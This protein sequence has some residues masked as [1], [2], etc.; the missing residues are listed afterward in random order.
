MI[1]AEADG[2]RGW[3]GE[4]LQVA[5]AFAGVWVVLAAL[6]IGMYERLM[7]DRQAVAAAPL[8]CVMS[9]PLAE[10]VQAGRLD[11]PPSAPAAQEAPLGAGELAAALA[12]VRSRTGELAGGVREDDVFF[13]DV[14]SIADLVGADLRQASSGA[15]ARLISPFGIFEILPFSR[16]IRR[17]FEPTDLSH[18]TRVINASLHL[19]VRGLDSVLP[20]E[21]TWNEETRAWTLASDDR[22]MRIAVAEDLFEITIDRSDRT[23]TIHYAGQQ[24]VH[25]RCCTGEGNNSPV[26]RWRVQNKAVWPAWR[27]YEGEHIPGGS[28]RNPLGARWLGTTARGHATGRAIGIHGTN[29]P[30]SIGRRISGGCIRLTNA[31]AIEMYNT[32][33]IGTRVVIK[34]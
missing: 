25:W 7:N 32:I 29:Q 9:A 14:A 13:V 17:N 16:T 2:V 34:E 3:F 19:P 5:L 11:A 27:S 26:G 28:R 10:R 33:P 12:R 23:L 6:D 21:I 18:P 20:V 15:P 31:H 24:L 1:A 30:S 4:L 8:A 22:R